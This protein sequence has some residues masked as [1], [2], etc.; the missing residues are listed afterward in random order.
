MIS[1][2]DTGATLVAMFKQPVI[3]LK[4]ELNEEQ[5]TIV[6]NYIVRGE[7]EELLESVF[8]PKKI[9]EKIEQVEK[10]KSFLDDLP[11]NF[12]KIEEGIYHK[13][14]IPVAVP[15]DY[16]KEY[17]NADEERKVALDNFWL[18]CSKHKDFQ[19]VKDLFP[20]M[21]DYG[22]PLT[23][24]GHIIGFRNAVLKEKGDQ[25]LNDFVVLSY[26]KIK[27]QKKSPKNYEV[28]VNKD[29]EYA[30]HN[31]KKYGSIPES[32]GTIYELYHDENRGNTVYTDSHSGKTNIVIGRS[33]SM[34]REECN[35]NRND[36]CSRGLHLGNVRYMR[37]TASKYGFGAV[38][39]MCIVNP[40]NV[41]AVPQ[42]QGVDEYGKF[43]CCEYLPYSFYEENENGEPIVPTET[44]EMEYVSD[45]IEFSNENNDF[46]FEND[47]VIKSVNDI[48][49]G[50]LKKQWGKKVEE[51]V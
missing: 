36:L 41:V 32:L 10:V 50:K 22:L 26:D 44:I 3:R 9:V 5:L 15:L 35:S 11:E 16:I 43:R 14:G 24:S 8:F 47:F 12:V 51:Q 38:N 4:S 37:D 34:P 17:V 40:L 30:Y 27:R 1:V 19:V 25:K 2:V 7:G 28:F 20:F 33:V 18:W 49:T 23:S 46:A 13:D 6:Q 48:N 42:A 45:V 39:L 31:V 21:M 29:E